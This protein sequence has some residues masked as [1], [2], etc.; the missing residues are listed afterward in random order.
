MNTT[1]IEKEYEL[2]VAKSTSRIA[3]K[4]AK[5]ICRL[6]PYIKQVQPQITGVDTGMG[7]WSFIGHGVGIA[8][9]HGHKGEIIII[10]NVDIDD[11]V[12]NGAP[13][14]YD[15]ATNKELKEICKL[16]DFL[17]NVS[18]LNC[19]TWQDGFNENGVVFVHSETSNQNNPFAI[20]NKDYHMDSAYYRGLVK[21][22]VPI[23][24]VDKS[25]YD[26]A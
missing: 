10:D 14:Y 2:S 6:F 17:V 7:S 23:V 8:T 5:E 15:F 9:E 1:S 11:I 18:E 24:F 19:S 22:K 16:L 26:A 20:P 12:Q 13:D 3:V 25:E 4:V 21:S